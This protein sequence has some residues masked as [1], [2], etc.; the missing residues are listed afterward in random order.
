VGRA[1]WVS[2]EVVGALTD[3]VFVHLSYLGLVIP[4]IKSTSIKPSFFRLFSPK[5]DKMQYA[6][7]HGMPAAEARNQSCRSTL[8]HAPVPL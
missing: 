7:I 4:I 5:K 1:I 8:R 3:T 6:H 2:F